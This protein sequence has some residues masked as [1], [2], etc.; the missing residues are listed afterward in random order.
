MSKWIE[1]DEQYIFNSDEIKY[2]HIDESKENITIFFKDG[3]R[4]SLTSNTKIKTV[5]AWEKILKSCD[6]DPSAWMHNAV[7]NL[8][9]DNIINN[10][11][12]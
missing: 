7:H 6:I 4:L 8:E 9:L 12:L 2:F 10:G 1:F 3:K 11:D 5:K